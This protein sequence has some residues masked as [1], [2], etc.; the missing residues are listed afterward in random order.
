MRVDKKSRLIGKP[1]NRQREENSMNDWQKRFAEKLETVQSVA[2]DRFE[3]RAQ[4]TLTP[5]YKQFAEFIRQYVVQADI[6]LAE[7]GIRTFRFG[8]SED[9]Y[10]LITFRHTGFEQCDAQAELFLAGKSAPPPTRETV[11]LSDVNASWC[12]NVFEHALDQFLDTLIDAMG[13]VTEMAV[14]EVPTA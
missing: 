9:I 1:R 2:R 11:S 4:D 14:V 7:L 3:Q 5:V 12:R 13:G 6:P 8:M 10:L